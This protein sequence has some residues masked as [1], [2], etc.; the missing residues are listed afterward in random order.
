MVASGRWRLSQG[1]KDGVVRHTVGDDMERRRSPQAVTARRGYASIGC[2]SWA[3]A[4]LVVALPVCAEQLQVGPVDPALVTRLMALP[5][6]T[7]HSEVRVD[8]DAARAETRIW[9]NTNEDDSRLWSPRGS[10]MDMEFRVSSV[11][12]GRDRARPPAHVTIEF[13]T[14]GELRPVAGVSPTLMVTADG[15]NVDLTQLAAPE[16]RSGALVFLT[17]TTS[18]PIGEFIRLAA[19]TRV[20]GRIW[21]HE[22]VLID[23]QLE[24]LRAYAVELLR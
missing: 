4:L 24:I 3:A 13:A 23:T 10:Q 22:F 8:A 15:R 12:H 16:A 7:H 20:E 9:I 2:E 19:S 5:R 11:S 14:L 18:V 6:S 1:C 21:G 17:T